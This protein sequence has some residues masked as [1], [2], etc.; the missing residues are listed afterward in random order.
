M[1]SAARHTTGR[2]CARQE[3][4]AAGETFSRNY[5]DQAY[6]H[7]L[8]RDVLGN[9]NYVVHG[10]KMYDVYNALGQGVRLEVGTNSFTGSL[11]QLRAT[12]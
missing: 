7:A 12:R 1:P 5:T 4:W 3:A 2:P 6:A 9:P 11:V 10:S 8:I